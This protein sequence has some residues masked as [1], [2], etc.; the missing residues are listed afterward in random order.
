M[1]T[2]LKIAD[3]NFDAAVAWGKADG[4]SSFDKETEVFV[5]EVPNAVLACVRPKGGKSC[6]W[7]AQTRVVAID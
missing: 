5:V 4:C 3:K 2:V 6:V 1:T 7:T